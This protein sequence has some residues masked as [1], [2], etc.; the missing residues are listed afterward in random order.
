MIQKG[1]VYVN[2][3][4][5]KEDKKLDLDS[6]IDER[7]LIVRMGKSKVRIIEV[8]SEKDLD[9]AR[10]AKEEVDAKKEEE[11]ERE[12]DDSDDM[13][14]EDDVEFVMTAGERI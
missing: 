2:G 4:Q 9:L 12:R 8:V 7:L 14:N 10:Q 13:E 1:E 11:L 6:L 3:V 5:V